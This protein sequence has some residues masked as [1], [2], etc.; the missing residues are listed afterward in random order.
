GNFRRKKMRDLELEIIFGLNDFL[1]VQ[2]AAPELP[3]DRDTYLD[4]P[5]GNA[6][7]TTCQQLLDDSFAAD[8]CG[9][10]LSHFRKATRT[11]VTPTIEQI[12]ARAVA[13]LDFGAMLKSITTAADASL[14]EAR[15]RSAISKI[16][17]RARSQPALACIKDSEGWERLIVSG[18]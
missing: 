13:D 17:E 12:A 9:L 4:E 11:R 15:W 6:A 3:M 14:K 16:V 1:P 7:D 10:P 5:A 18:V 2:K 8:V